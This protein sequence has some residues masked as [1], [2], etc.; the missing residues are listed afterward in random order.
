MN[1]GNSKTVLITGGCGFIGCNLV[2]HLARRGYA[3]RVLDNLSNASSHWGSVLGKG[4][5][6]PSVRASVE[7]TIGDIRDEDTV[8]RVVN[9]VGAV[10]HLAAYPG[11]T[12]SL[13]APAETWE[14]NTGG[15]LNLLEASRRSDVGCFVFASSNAAVGDQEPPI[16]ETRIPRPLSPYG[17]SKLAGE[18]LC[19]AYYRS[20]GLRTLSLRFSNCVGPYS[21][22]KSSVVAT[23]IRKAV[24]GEPL[25]IH[26]S[27]DQTRDFVHVSDVCRA[28]DLCLT[29]RQ[30]DQVG[31]ET[32]WGEVF[33]V[34][35]GIETSIRELCS[36]IAEVS[37]DNAEV[38]Y[39]ERRE[40]DIQRNY[41]DI[42]R[43]RRV[44]GFEPAVTLREGIAE[45]WERR[46]AGG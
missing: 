21:D 39:E 12:E 11:V 25:T 18:A 17:A 41:S 13:K 33:Q 19:S 7:L 37:G 9:G 27:G 45:L 44:L 2:S 1:S 42:S 16:D 26:G 3:L 46:L 28:I 43:A 38:V 4:C 6:R 8:Y 40:G 10:V 36:I 30:K 24:A 34:G 15:T 31:R 29:L 20:F 23:F 32:P 5:P 35:T 14:V 22:R